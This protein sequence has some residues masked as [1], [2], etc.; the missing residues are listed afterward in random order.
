[1]KQL[2]Q[3]FTSPYFYIFMIT[4]Y[5]VWLM[6]DSLR[7]PYR[8]PAGVISYLPSIHFNPTNN[9]LR[10]LVAVLMPPIAC[11]IFWLLTGSAWR[12][13]LTSRKIRI[14]VAALLVIS[15][16]ALACFMG[17]VQGSTDSKNQPQ[18]Y[19]GPYNYALLDTFHEG[20]TLG[21]AVSYQ[22]KDLKPYRDFVIIHGVFQD[23]LRTV[24]AFK[25][26]GQ[27][28]GA[29]RAFGVMLLM[30]T[31][32]LYYALLLV[33]FEGNVYKSSAGMAA[34]ALL[35]FPSLTIP[36][37]GKSLI[38][39]AFPFRDIPTILF[40]MA[41]V[42]GLRAILKT[43]KWSQI[44]Y[45]GLIGFIV[46]AGF[47]NSIDRAMYIA[48]LS[49]VWLIM[50]GL[51]RYKGFWKQTFLP[52]VFGGLVGVPVLGMA[53]K[54]DFIDLAKYLLSM[55]RYKEY[56]D[57]VPFVRPDSG[58]SL[59]LLAVSFGVLVVGWYILKTLTS[60]AM[61]R[62]NFKHKVK[63]ASELL[64][65]LVEQYY[66]V[67]LLFV[68]SVFFLRSAIG[69][70]DIGHLVYSIQWLYLLI[71]FLVINYLSAS[72]KKNSI[73]LALISVILL[74]STLLYY[75]GQTYKINL[76]KDTFPIHASDTNFIRPDY[77]QTADYLK[78]N[79]KPSES[80]MTLTSEG[81]Y[82]YFVDKPSPT[83]W[84]VL[85]YAYTHPQRQEIADKLANDQNIK[86]IVTND[87]WTS[88][89]D[90]VPNPARFPEVYSVLTDKYE[91]QTGFGQQ[92]V[93]VRK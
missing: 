22:Q 71:A 20:E 80:F 35:L 47:A 90:Y 42:A 72:R 41:A 9:L 74:G 75:A 93:W 48:V 25:L 23:P 28:I 91:P 49:V 39:V 79:L 57:G 45:S 15:A 38:G 7:L 66:V 85:W 1:M 10:F 21:P 33:L 63:T 89:F 83:R 59:I 43:K 8:G 11:L 37:I 19:G 55:S 34:L 77:K 60:P 78:Q 51:V 56:L 31:F 61:K 67:I 87:N 84:Y 14:V 52:Y 40:L 32:I 30:F 18:T 86:Y 16:V 76:S 17:I 36:F 68:T 13:K 27:S 58:V 26:F 53:L 81:S 62:G 64:G 5:G 4:Y 12:G 46:A 65:K 50:V 29:A 6:W 88:N 24:I 69:R 54:W 92:T 2:K 73:A 3:L 44:I 82:Y 70:A